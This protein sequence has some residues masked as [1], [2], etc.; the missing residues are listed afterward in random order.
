[1]AKS[2]LIRAF[3]I[4]GGV[5]IIVGASLMCWMLA[6]EDERSVIKV[7][8]EEGKPESLT[9]EALSLV[10]GE[11]CEYTILLKK[12][13]ASKYDLGLDFVETEKKALSNYARVKIIS[14][15]VVISD[16]LLADAFV[17][18]KVVLPVDFDEGKNIELK[19]VY[20]LP[21]DVGNEAKNA[22]AVFEL[23]L[24]ASNE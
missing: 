2:K 12:A 23:L 24:T 11:E 19:V 14:N 15:G 4:V 8:P 5:L 7:K 9:F 3:L 16:E 18:E 6:T 13:S 1:M 20:Y 10:P 22:D 21:L 17:N